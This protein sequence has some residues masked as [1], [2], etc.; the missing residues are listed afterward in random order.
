[1]VDELP[2]CPRQT[3]YP[4]RQRLAWES[5]SGDPSGRHPQ[6]SPGFLIHDTGTLALWESSGTMVAGHARTALE[7]AA[8]ES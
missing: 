5:F 6:A 2:D 1:M 4:F 8:S 7:L 3:G